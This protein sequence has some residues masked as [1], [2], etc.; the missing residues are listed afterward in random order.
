MT[1][2][3]VAA[4]VQGI[5]FDIHN[6]PAEALCDGKQAVQKEAGRI[7]ETSRRMHAMLAG[8]GIETGSSVAVAAK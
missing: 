1:Y 4:G 2:A 8:I 6:N 5:E 3:F 7:I